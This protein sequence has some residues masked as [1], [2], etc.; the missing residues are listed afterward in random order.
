MET[1]KQVQDFLRGVPSINCGGCGV[2]ALT[3]HRWLKDH[4]VESE[5]VFL[6]EMYDRNYQTNAMR[7]KRGSGMAEAPAHAVIKHRKRYKDCGGYRPKSWGERVVKMSEDAVVD[8][9]NLSRRWNPRF[10]RSAIPAIEKETGVD[11]SDLKL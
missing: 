1:L 9:I 2:A 5:M 6:H 7:M 10:K 3:M 11:L 8:A 4:G